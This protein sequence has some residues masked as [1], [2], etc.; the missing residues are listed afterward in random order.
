VRNEK[1][2]AEAR[3]L[4]GMSTSAVGTRYQATAREA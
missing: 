1:L 2:V 4:S 3:N